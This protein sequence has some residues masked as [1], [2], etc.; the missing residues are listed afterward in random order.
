L[1][2]DWPPSV[3]SDPAASPVCGWILPNLLD[4]G[5]MI[6]D[7]QGHALGALQGV[8]RSSLDQGVGGIQ[9]PI[10]AFH[11]I[12]LPGSPS[13]RFGEPP[14]GQ[15]GNP[16]DPLDKGVNPDL[17]AFVNGLLS[18]TRQS[19]KAFGDLLESIGRTA[20]GTGSGGSSGQDAG[21]ALLIGKPL[22]LLR[23]T[24]SLELD[25]GPA[26]SQGWDDSEKTLEDQSGSISALKIAVR[27][28]DRRKLGN[29]WLGDDGLVGFFEKQDYS[30]F[31][32]A[33]GLEGKSDSNSYCTYSA[34]PTL[35]IDEPLKVTL[36]M[37][38]AR[39]V[40]VTSGILPR[41]IFH[42]PDRDL[43]EILE[44]K[45]VIF[46]TGPVVGPKTDKAAPKIHMP[47]P[48]DLYGQWS[49][50][51]HP[52]IKVWQEAAIADTQKE[53]GSFPE[54]G[55]AIVEGWLKLVTAPLA[56]RVF[57]VKGTNPVAPPGGNN[58]EQQPEL[59]VVPRGEIT[60]S[61]TVSGADRIKLLDNEVQVFEADQLPLP[62]QLVVTV[63]QNTSFTLMAIARADP[64][65]VTQQANN[66]LKRTIR[67]QVK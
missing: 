66:E 43:A 20:S 59:F 62:A 12:G 3:A 56:V 64:L 4:A 40:S 10:E 33:F 49:W 39:G 17:R 41:Q 6:Y 26:R 52:A 13:F 5:L 65:A 19:G 11:W 29:L 30:H 45:Q 50:T 47:Q 21:L 55:L 63:N 35:S 15:N 16:N 1:T 54:T 27:L 37:D 23:A 24:I 22:A 57:T 7:A 32:P 25:G 44:H 60:L 31:F 36:L 18:V 51:H 9:E 58:G 61:W 67:L 38:P 8:K 28:G 42:L 48:S 34:T 2:I 46:Y 14:A 53:S